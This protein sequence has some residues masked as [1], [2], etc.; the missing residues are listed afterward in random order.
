[1]LQPPVQ[2]EMARPLPGGFPTQGYPAGGYPPPAPY[3]GIPSYP[4]G[5]AT[6]RLPTLGPALSNNITTRAHQAT[7]WA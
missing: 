6:R 5:P 2:Q 3:Q 1:M 4:A 7:F